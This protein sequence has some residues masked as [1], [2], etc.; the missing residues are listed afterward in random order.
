MTGYVKNGQMTK[1][2][3]KKKSRKPSGGGSGGVPQ[4][5]FPSPLMGEGQGEGEKRTY[6]A[7]NK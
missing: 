6:S 5:H 1:R 4:P 7:F 3:L 2:P